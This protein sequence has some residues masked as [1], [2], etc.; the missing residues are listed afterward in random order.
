M[1][2]L[3]TKILMGWA[4]KFAIPHAILRFTIFRTKSRV[5]ETLILKNEK[6]SII[7]SKVGEPTCVEL[8]DSK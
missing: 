5:E 3:E 6:T 2:V 4:L 7:I 1:G 8:D